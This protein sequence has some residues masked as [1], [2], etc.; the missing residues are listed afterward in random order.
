MDGWE[1]GRKEVK[2][3]E[4]WLRSRLN[5]LLDFRGSQGQNLSSTRLRQI[6]A[7]FR[8]ER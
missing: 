3:W 6:S 2:L 4:G 7:Y 5:R 8:G 1:E